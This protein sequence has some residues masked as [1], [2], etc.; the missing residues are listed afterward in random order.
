VQATPGGVDELNDLVRGVIITS[1]ACW[2]S[3]EVLAA[4]MGDEGVL[5]IE[6]GSPAQIQSWASAAAAGGYL[7]LLEKL[8]DAGAGPATL[9]C[10]MLSP[11]TSAAQSGQIAAL[12]LILER[13]ADPKQSLNLSGSGYHGSKKGPT[14]PGDVHEAV[15]FQDSDGDCALL[16]AAL[17]GKTHCVRMLL[18]AG[19]NVYAS[20]GTDTTAVKHAADNG[21][22]KTVQL[23]LERGANVNCGDCDAD[24]PL[25]GAAESGHLEACKLLLT[26]GANLHQTNSYGVTA[27]DK[28]EMSDCVEVAAWLREQMKGQ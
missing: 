16:L 19:A 28:A 23:L 14:T 10:G 13:V 8:L 24:T 3:P 17:N 2:D 18:D 25:I 22:V 5:D 20:N 12:Q 27:A 4:A 15:N 7:H 11:M 21:H 26:H 6:T 9:D 1:M